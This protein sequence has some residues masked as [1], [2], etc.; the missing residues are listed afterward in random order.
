MKVILCKEI[1]KLGQA[2]EVITVKDGYA[3]NFLIPKGLALT[4][5]P[6]SLKVVEQLK[7]QKEQAAQKEKAAAEELAQRLSKLSCTIAMHAGQDDKLFGAVTTADI[8]EAFEA[9]GVAID[10]KMILLSAPINQLGVY[11][12]SVRLHPEVTAQ[13]RVWVVK[14]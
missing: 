12:V 3:R 5:T 4:C 6:K 2:G 7:R 13:T 11:Q 8:K 9:E 1:E 14:K 10:K